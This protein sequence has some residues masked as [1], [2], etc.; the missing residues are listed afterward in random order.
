MLIQIVMSTMSEHLGYL[1]VQIAGTACLYYLARGQLAS[2]IN[3]NLLSKTISA[4]LE[5]MRMFPSSLQVSP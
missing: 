5:P 2:Q 4:I 1:Q 3:P